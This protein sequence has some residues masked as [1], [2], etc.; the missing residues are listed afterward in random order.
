M[1]AVF[2]GTD[3]RTVSSL[4]RWL[5]TRC[6]RGNALPKSEAI[7]SSNT[8]RFSSAGSN[9]KVDPNIIPACLCLSDRTRTIS[10]GVM[11][12]A[13]PD[14]PDRFTYYHQALCKDGL[15]GSHYWEVEWDGGVVEV[16]VAYKDISRKGSGKDCC[17]GHN[18]LSWK[19]VCFPTG[20]TFW[21][22]NL[23]NAQIP[24][25]HSRKVGV[26]LDYPRG[27]L[28]FYGVCGDGSLTLLHRVKT[29]FSKPLYP[30]FCVDLG[31]TLKICNI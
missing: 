24:P 5:L 20:C 13:H 4:T 12:H 23:F 17:F 14:H 29:T 28:C 6:C 19:L 27:T 7:L 2:S 8:C 18:G 26:H 16:A 10:W 9:M 3:R 22:D 25:V 11:E 1:S 30:G 31:S 21:H 15:T